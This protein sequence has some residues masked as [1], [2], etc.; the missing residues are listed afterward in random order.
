MAL[1]AGGPRYDLDGNECGEVT[2]EQKAEAVKMLEALAVK[3]N[4]EAR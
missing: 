3:K 2:A 4:R 1:I